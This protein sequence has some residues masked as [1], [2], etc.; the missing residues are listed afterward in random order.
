MTSVWNI[1]V[2][3]ERIGVVSGC[4]KEVRVDIYPHNNYYSIC[5][6]TFLAAASLLICSFLNFLR[7]YLVNQGDLN[8]T[9][10]NI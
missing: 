7:F 2:W 6:S 9:R 8:S 5:N 4:C 10:N 3:L 1:W